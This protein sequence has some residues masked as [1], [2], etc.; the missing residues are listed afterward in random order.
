MD[1]KGKRM[2][3]EENGGTIP[4]ERLNNRFRCPYGMIAFIDGADV[5]CLPRN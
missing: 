2:L 5:L 1:P 4:T 3:V